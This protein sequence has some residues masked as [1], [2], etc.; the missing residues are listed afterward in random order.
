MAMFR[1]WVKHKSGIGAITIFALLSL[2]PLISSGCVR[3][4]QRGA[5]SH[6]AFS[7]QPPTLADVTARYYDGCVCNRE[8][9][10]KKHNCTHFLSNAFIL[11]GFDDMQKNSRYSLHCSQGRPVRAQEFLK[12]F[13]EEAERFHQGRP[14]ANTG[15]WA[16]YQEKPGG[17]HVF[18]LDTN[19]G[20]FYGTADCVE[21]PVQ[22]AYQW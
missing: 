11:A 7:S 16:M 4:T 5:L 8:T 22:W 20:K 19:T 14:P 2:M 21:W 3:Q 10:F 6:T 15:I 13:Q 12:W 1:M 18:L 9:Q 17:H